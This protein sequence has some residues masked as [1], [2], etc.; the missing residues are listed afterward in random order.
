[1][2]T[3]TEQ[4]PVFT[5][6]DVG[7]YPVS[8]TV[9]LTNGQTATVKRKIV[10][11]ET[12]DADFTFANDP[13][14]EIAFTDASS[15]SSSI[16]E[17]LWNFDDGETSDL[18]NPVHAF[19]VAGTYSVSL[20]VRT[21]AGSISTIT[22]D[23]ITTSSMPLA[24]F[25]FVSDD[26]DVD[27]TDESVVDGS[28]ISSWDWDFGDSS[29]TSTSQ[30]PSYTYATDGTYTVTLTIEDD[31]GITSTVSY[32]AVVEGGTW[33]RS[34]DFTVSDGDWNGDGLDNCSAGG[35][36]TYV[37]GHG[38][39]PT[40]GV[41]AG[42]VKDFDGSS[43][44]ILS[45]DYTFRVEAGLSNSELVQVLASIADSSCSPMTPTIAGF[46][47]WADGA[48]KHVANANGSTGFVDAGSTR[49]QI[50][51]R[52]VVVTAVYA[53]ITGSGFNP[54]TTTPSFTYAPTHL[55][56]DFTDTTVSD[57]T[58]SAWAWDFGD[59]GTSTS[60]NPSHTYSSNGTYVVSLTVTV[61]GH[62]YIS[63]RAIHVAADWTHTFDFT[64][65]DGGWI[66]DGNLEGVYSG[67]QGQYSSGNYWEETHTSGVG[68]EARLLQMKK[69]LTLTTLVR[70]EVYFDVKKGNYFSTSLNA[71]SLYRNNTTVM[72]QISVASL[73]DG[74]QVSIWSGSQAIAT[75][76]LELLANYAATDDPT[77]YFHVTKIIVD[78]TGSDPF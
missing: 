46:E 30:N 70:V 65:N 63:T 57:G 5:Y 53:T 43:S 1:M 66:N 19:A 44:T 42:L 47:I 16:T 35:A 14:P 76:R 28:T 31:C 55:D 38:W 41:N 50:G 20:T 77:S 21:S 67:T 2:T 52:Y 39:R 73:A 61:S 8:L 18:Q 9:H 26:L 56:V 4:N 27:F 17:W 68:L 49:I 48:I 24:A 29:G 71:F 10:I 72:T 36:W 3:S 25:T 32:D 37:P 34:F 54:F 40:P 15:A 74:E 60:Q 64:V 11:F 69:T 6:P 59:A 7:V 51:A 58:I 12:I 62:D 23:T 78:G 13:C 45:V 75:L 33:S 22:H